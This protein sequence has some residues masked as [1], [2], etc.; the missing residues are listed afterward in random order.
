MNTVLNELRRVG[1][2]SHDGAFVAAAGVEN[3][4]QIDVAG[5]GDLDLET[6][7]TTT[8]LSSGR[9]RSR[10]RRTSGSR[11]GCVLGREIHLE[12]DRFGA[13]RDKRIGQSAAIVDRVAS[14]FGGDGDAV[15][16]GGNAKS[17][18]EDL[19]EK[20]CGESGTSASAL[21][22][23]RI[24]DGLDSDREKLKIFKYLTADGGEVQITAKS[25]DTAGLVTAIGP[26]SGTE[27]GK[28]LRGLAFD[29]DHLDDLGLQGKRRTEE[30]HGQSK[31]TT[32]ARL[33]RR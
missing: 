17:V 20:A 5:E 10:T 16:F 22:G 26:R 11:G 27:E 14:K 33:V 9:G 2:G 30:R 28:G 29:G 15:I 7:V 23:G 6:A 19:E 4:L 31:V 13:K 1:C 18:S 32:D 24:L 21:H 8:A 12:L 3:E 25:N